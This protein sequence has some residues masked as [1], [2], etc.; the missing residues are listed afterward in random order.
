MIKVGDKVRVVKRV[1]REKGWVNSWVKEMDECIGKVYTVQEID[2]YGVSFEDGP[3][4][5]PPS[6]LE[7]VDDKKRR[8]HY[9]MIIAWA[10]GESIQFKNIHDKWEDILAPV[11]YED[12]VYRIKPT[13]P[14]WWENIPEHGIL[15]KSKDS[16]P[17]IYHVKDMSIVLNMPDK[18]DYR[19]LT[20]D[21]ISKF[22]G[23]A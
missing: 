3:F 8:P 13:E 21:E 9:D 17:R 1:D 6:S 20:D 12:R 11:F 5:F 2:K 23:Q 10:E 16:I 18:D 14:K 15:I 7:L 4:N 22:L 19:P